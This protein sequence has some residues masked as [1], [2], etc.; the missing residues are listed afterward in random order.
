MTVVVKFHGKSSSRKKKRCEK[1]PK[2]CRSKK[3]NA[4]GHKEK[5]YPYGETSGKKSSPGK[6]ICICEKTAGS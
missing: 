2:G 4:H 6:E 3:E 1:G 5:N